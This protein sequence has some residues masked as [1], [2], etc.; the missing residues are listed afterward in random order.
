MSRLIKSYELILHFYG[1]RLKNRE[2]G[3]IERHEQWREQYRNLNSHS[4]NFLRITRILK[5]LG[6]FGL[7]HYK[8][9]FLEHFIKEIW[10]ER[11]LTNCD[12]SCENFWIGTLKDTKDREELEK[13][14]AG[15]T[16]KQEAEDKQAASEH[17][18]EQQ[19]RH[20]A[21][22]DDDTSDTETEAEISIMDEET[23]K[24]S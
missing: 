2:T 13:K 6:E 7:E 20:L 9:P 8:K 17:K 14:I 18:A 19:R 5:C 24:K 15:F 11:T 4:H 22:A 16:K 23:K 1:C 3:E 12:S 10:E 21:G